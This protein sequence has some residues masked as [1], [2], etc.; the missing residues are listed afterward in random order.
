[1]DNHE[2]W[3]AALGEIEIN[4]SRANFITWFNGTKIVNNK[5]GYI[6]ITV[7]NTFIKDWLENKYY[8]I[9]L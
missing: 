6:V 7:P 4:L 5:D 9:V 8:K 3:Q 1:M 2:L